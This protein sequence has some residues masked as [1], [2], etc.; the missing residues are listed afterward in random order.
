MKIIKNN[1]VRL[2][3]KK[4]VDERILKD[5]YKGFLNYPI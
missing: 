2:N 1:D 5:A 4:V 3:L